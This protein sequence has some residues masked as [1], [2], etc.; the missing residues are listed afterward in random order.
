MRFSDQPGDL[1]AIKTPFARQRRAPRRIPVR[2]IESWI[3]A[4]VRLRLIASQKDRGE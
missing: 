1:S 2:E 4:A 3:D